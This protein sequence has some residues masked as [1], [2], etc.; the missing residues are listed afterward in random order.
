MPTRYGEE[1]VRRG[2]RLVVVT[3]VN[4][5]T[6]LRET[7]VNEKK[8]EGRSGSYK[9]LFPRTLLSPRY[10][11][12]IFCKCDY[13]K[14][15]V[16]IRINID[17]SGETVCYIVKCLRSLIRTHKKRP[18]SLNWTDGVNTQDTTLNTVSF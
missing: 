1:C 17:I 15:L 10:I 13:K 3:Q 14:R 5:S 7:E 6:K 8:D 4:K 16:S 2:T 11:T 12:Q 18:L 9:K